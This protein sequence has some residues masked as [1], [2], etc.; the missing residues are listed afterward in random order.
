MRSGASSRTD[1][2]RHFFRLTKRCVWWFLMFSSRPRNKGTKRY[3]LLQLGGGR[4]YFAKSGESLEHLTDKT[5]AFGAVFSPAEEST[6]RSSSSLNFV[7][8]E[9][10]ACTIPTLHP[11]YTFQPASQDVTAPSCSFGS[12]E[13]MFTR[14]ASATT[15]SRFSLSTIL[16]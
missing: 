5:D 15:W 6:S 9:P 11:R 14:F 2:T 13:G 12:T 7:F 10:A 4:C 16:L 1:R 8:L 3:T